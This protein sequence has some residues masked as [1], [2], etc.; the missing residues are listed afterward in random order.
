MSSSVYLSCMNVSISW[1]RVSLLGAGAFFPLPR[2]R[3]LP[4][5]AG[6][7]TTFLPRP[8]PTLAPRTPPRPLLDT[9]RVT[10]PPLLVILPPRARGTEALRPLLPTEADLMKYVLVVNKS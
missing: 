10:L 6:F 2:P 7:P 3:P 9:P 5:P 8:A 1:S 4:R